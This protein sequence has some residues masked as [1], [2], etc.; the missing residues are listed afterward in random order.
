MEVNKIYEIFI[1][2]PVISTDSR[3]ISEN[4]LFFALKGNKFNG[5][6]Y[7]SSAIQQG[8][9]F[10]IIDE[11]DFKKDDNYILVHNV[12]ETLQRLANYHRKQTKAKI[13]AITGTNGK[14]TTKELLAAV[15]SKKFN[16]IATP[17]NLNNHI[18]VPLTLL[19]MNDSTEIGIIEMGANHIGEIGLLCEI[20]EPDFGLITNIGKAHLEGFGSFEGVIKA[21]TEL[22]KFLDKKNGTIFYNSDNSILINE[23]ENAKCFKLDYGKGQYCACQGKILDS[24]L[25]LK[26]NFK[27]SSIKSYDVS[28]KLVGDYNFENTLAACC[29]GLHF[30]IPPQNIADAIANYQPSNNRSQFIKSGNN[31]II[32]D[33]YNANPSSMKVALMNFNQNKSDLKKVIIL[34]EMFELGDQ[35]FVEHSKLIELIKS[36]SFDKVY[37]VGKDFQIINNPYKTFNSAELL[38]EYLLKFPIQNSSILIKGSRGV[39]LEKVAEIFWS[40]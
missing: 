10:A 8:A 9:A 4:C 38:K 2:H 16:I 26:F 1:K 21:K 24:N 35:S 33:F 22:Y 27:S 6:E 30:N 11:K 28:T 32:F 20:A 15:L 36:L 12:L 7:A 19:S 5:N 18:G 40:K 37:L 29:I 25:Y 34:G 31:D 14:T 13:I 17:G 39:K 23:T 3:N